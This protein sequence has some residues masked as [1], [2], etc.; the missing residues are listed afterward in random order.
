MALAA[1]SFLQLHQEATDAAV[2]E[3]P[4]RGIVTVL[5]LAA[6]C[7][8]GGTDSRTPD[9]APIG[10]DVI[11]APV[12][13]GPV[14][15]PCDEVRIVR[16]ENRGSEE[17]RIDTVTFTTG[18]A[19]SLETLLDVPRIVSAGG[20]WDLAVRVLADAPGPAS[21]H[22]EVVSDEGTVSTDLAVD[23]TY[24]S[25]R[26]ETF[27]VGRPKVDVLLMV[28]HS[29]TA[30]DDYGDP[31]A[32]GIPALLDALDAVADWQ[33]AL[34]TDDDGC[35]NG[36]V[37]SNADPDADFLIAHAF[38]ADPDASELTE[39]LLELASR[40]LAQNAPT[41]CNAPFLRAGS[42]LHVVTVSDEPEQSGRDGSYWVSDFFVYSDAVTVSAIADANGDCGQGADGYADAA[43]ETDGLVLDICTA[44]GGRMH[45]LAGALPT[46]PPRFVLAE[47]ALPGSI[48]ATVDGSR[49]GATYEERSRTVML[50]ETVAVGKTVEIG[51]AVPG[52]C[53]EP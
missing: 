1:G 10:P 27:T 7:K 23:V 26:T 36:R 16:I 53:A 5:V 21:A 31:I 25:E 28:D 32:R 42:Q 52:V 34:V 49:I 47:E 9:G 37:F 3:E 50:A 39:S 38:D 13:A 29:G 44:F 40:A 22:V 48:V 24:A 45:A 30:E 46:L 8:E 51:Y 12:S 17:H 11:V 41:E 19:V 15:V 35:R 20:S 2:R 43:E 6:A 4:L 14:V 33:L 18:S